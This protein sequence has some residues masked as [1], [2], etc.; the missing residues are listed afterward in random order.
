MNILLSIH[1]ELDHSAGAPGVTVKLAQALRDRGHD[2][3]A[4]SFDDLPPLRGRLRALLF[5]WRVFAHVLAHPEYDVMDM[6]SGDGWVVN[7]VRRLT[8]WRAHQL[9]LTRSHGLEQLAHE[10]FM[11]SCAQ[12]ITK[13][14]WKYP[15]YSGGFHLWE[16]R[17]SLQLADALLLLNENERQFVNRRFGVDFERV[18]KVSNG[19]DDYFTRVAQRLLAAPPAVPEGPL[20]VAFVGRANHWKGFTYLAEAMPPILRANPQMRLGLFGTG[21]T[22]QDVLGAFAEDVR[23]QISVVPQYDNR[24]LPAMYDGYQIFAFPAVGEPFGIATLEAMA[25]GLVPVVSD[26]PGPGEYMRNGVNGIVVP[27][28]DAQALRAGIERLIADRGTWA[29]LQRGALETAVKFSWAE[30]AAGF[31]NIYCQHRRQR[32][33]ASA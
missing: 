10:L 32:L 30:L 14:S 1:H 22:E 5:P 26:S 17:R 27:V 16:C 29:A 2:V 21:G 11:A 33:L 31:E 28:H 12:G 13:A 19:I 6:S 25:C 7:V 24:D 8:G 20:N 9:S 18:V 23:G 4:I 3:R 15:I